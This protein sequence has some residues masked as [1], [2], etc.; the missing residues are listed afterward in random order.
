MGSG[1]ARANAG[2]KRMADSAKLQVKTFCLPKKHIDWLDDNYGR[3]SHQL[4]RK[5]LQDHIDESVA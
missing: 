4:V 1:G 2:R 3:D 5:L